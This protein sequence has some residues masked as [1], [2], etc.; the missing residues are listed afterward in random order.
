MYIR[1]LATDLDGTIA[2]QDRVPD[3]V[4]DTLLEA[5]ADGFQIILVTGRTLEALSSIRPFHELCEAIIAENGA[6]VHFPRSGI[7][8]LPF[9]QIAPE[10]VTALAA[11]QIPFEAGRSIL[12]TWEPY[13]KD[14]SKTIT[15]AHFPATV[16]YNKGAV[17][18]MPPGATKGS[19]LLF[20]LQE[21]GY[22]RHH[23]IAFGDA[24]N[25]RSFFEQAELAVAVSNAA[26]GIQ[27]LADVQLSLPNGKGVGTF[28]QQ[29]MKGNIPIIQNDRGHSISLGK[30]DSKNCYQIHPL[31]LLRT[32]LCIVGSSGSGKSWLA[33]HLI[34]Q[35]LEKDYQVCI[36]DPEG[37][38]RGLRAFPHT[39]LLGGAAEPPPSVDTV[40]TMMEYAN[41]SVI[42]DLS[43]YPVD[44]QTPYVEK[45]MHALLQL[46]RKNGKPQWILIDEAHYFLRDPN[47]KLTQLVS[48][49]LPFGGLGLITY[50]IGQVD[51][52][53]RE[54]IDHWLLTQVKEEDE[55]NLIERGLQKKYSCEDLSRC[56]V[57]S[58][59]RG[60]VLVALDP[61]WVPG[62]WPKVVEFG[63]VRR[64]I[65]HIRHLH[66]YLYAPLPSYRQFY[67]NI[68][69]SSYQG[70]FTASSLW[71]FG[72]VLKTIPVTT[73]RY[74]VRRGDFQRWL[75]DVI[76]DSILAKRIRRI[77][78]RKPK[79]KRLRKELCE[80]VQNRLEELQKLV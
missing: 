70:P 60:E 75:E 30:S 46:H 69:D 26:P 79:G 28:I 10:I 50:Q 31:N 73:L 11:Q 21:L 41:L 71:E 15:K 23:L 49:Y 53:I 43:L 74:H 25:D 66:K 20:T 6:V 14:I 47:S 48:D 59:K 39:L 52:S 13:D 68:Q 76:H 5:K 34:E 42:L 16:E 37:D 51:I 35:L 2:K 27:Q 29:I 36:I 72:E 17:M 4:W 24:E 7:T 33:G 56:L 63:K 40:V 61:E 18:V 38:Y 57:S 45:L 64:A 65:P 54:Q 58:L 80:V 44:K 9:G 8:H 12:A 1:L 78:R 55:L 3:P 67:F 62:P 77:Q 22:S 32:N 19:G